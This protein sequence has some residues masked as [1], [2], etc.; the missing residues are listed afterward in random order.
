M[1]HLPMESACN[2]ALGG[3][4]LSAGEYLLYDLVAAT[5]GEPHPDDPRHKRQQA[6]RAAELAA[7]KAASDERRTRLGITGSVLRRKAA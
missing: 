3:D 5:I 7:A 2:Q 4:G 6:E 1:R